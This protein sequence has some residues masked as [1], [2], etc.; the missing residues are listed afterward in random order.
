MIVT[1]FFSESHRGFLDDYFL[2]SFPYE[3][4]LD[5]R[6]RKIGQHGDGSFGNAQWK[7]AM[8]KKVEYALE[9]AQGDEPFVHADADIQFFG[10]IKEEIE[11]ALKGCDIVFQ[12][13]CPAFC[14]GFWAAKP[15]QRVTDLMSEV[16]CQM[17][18]HAHDQ[19]AANAI[20]KKYP[21]LC[22]AGK[23]S[24]RFW[25]YGRVRRRKWEGD[26]DFEVPKNILMHHG[27]WTCG[28][29]NKR[30]LMNLVRLKCIQ[31]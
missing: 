29:Q 18:K 8:R 28:E 12:D 23:L 9:M 31:A 6:V 13:D 7:K 10:P 26:I 24:N 4:G 30:T 1:T 17:D 22:R 5:L 11:I 3:P 15:G 25:T 27:N 20:L 14:M 2:P 16:L 21:D 19:A